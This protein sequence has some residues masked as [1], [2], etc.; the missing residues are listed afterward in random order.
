MDLPSLP[1]TF[2][3][4]T[5]PNLPPIP[6]PPRKAVRKLLQNNRFT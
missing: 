1:S 5:K 3:S 4:P 2:L 6:S